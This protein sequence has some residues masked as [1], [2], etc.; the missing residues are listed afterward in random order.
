MKADISRV[1]CLIQ[2]ASV[3]IRLQS[4]M[5]KHTPLKTKKLN[6]NKNPERGWLFPLYTRES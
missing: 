4:I 3:G 2:S 1:F 6:F 5:G